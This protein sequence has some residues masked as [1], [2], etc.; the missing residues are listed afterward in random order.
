M[1]LESVCQWDHDYVAQLVTPPQFSSL[2]GPP[3]SILVEAMLTMLT[4]YWRM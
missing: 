3:P 1:T 2:I 4:R